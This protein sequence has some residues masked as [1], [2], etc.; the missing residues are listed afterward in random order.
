MLGLLNGGTNLGVSASTCGDKVIDRLG[1]T[2]LSGVCSNDGFDNCNLSDSSIGSFLD[3]D[4]F[5]VGNIDVFDK[6]N[7]IDSSG[8]LFDLDLSGVLPND[9]F[10]NSSLSEESRIGSCVKSLDRFD[11]GGVFG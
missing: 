3:D 4:L 6:C 11:L 7:F 5:G 8:V 10:D 9:V 1:N 2:F